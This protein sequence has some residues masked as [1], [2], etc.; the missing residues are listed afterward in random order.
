AGVGLVVL[1]LGN[2]ATWDA[3]VPALWLPSL[4]LGLALT[5]WLGPWGALLAAAD[6]LLVRLLSGAGDAN[7]LVPAIADAALTGG[8]LLLA[9]WWYVVLAEGRLQVDEPRSATAFLLLVPGAA[10][11]LGALARAWLSGDANLGDLLAQQWVS[12]ALSALALAPPV[13]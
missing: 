7:S 10:L 8:E 9:W 5:F 4:G 6:Q 3:S 2:P 1:H 12:R 11:G 13:L